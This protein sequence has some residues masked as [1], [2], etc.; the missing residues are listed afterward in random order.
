VKSEKRKKEKHK[1]KKKP[2]NLEAGHP[3]LF[4][5]PIMRREEGR[6]KK[7]KKAKT[8]VG[9]QIRSY[10]HAQVLSDL[11]KLDSRGEEERQG[12]IGLAESPVARFLGPTNAHQWKLGERTART[13]VHGEYRSPS[14]HAGLQRTCNP[15]S[16]GE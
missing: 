5:K 2:S 15:K 9:R 13:S 3:F 14:I 11:T 1:I 10:Y 4:W 7:K 16:V 12:L 8:A 6:E